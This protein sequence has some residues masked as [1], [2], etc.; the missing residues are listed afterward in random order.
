[1]AIVTALM[2]ALLMLALGAGVTLTTMTETA[3]A[4]NYRDATQAMYAADAGIDLAV[5]RLRTI[6]DWHALTDPRG[7]PLLSGSLAALVQVSNVDPRII[8]TVTVS[9]DPTGDADVLVVQSSAG[10]AGGVRRSVQAAIRRMPAD[11]DGTRD[12][13]VT[14]WR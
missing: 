5:E 13:V 12:V 1:M 14:A 2:A 3:V 8:V 9:P 10:G 11:A 6:D 7:A 4:A